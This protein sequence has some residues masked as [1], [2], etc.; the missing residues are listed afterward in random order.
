[1]DFLND[2]IQGNDAA[3]SNKEIGTALKRNA[4]YVFRYARDTSPVSSEWAVVSLLT[5]PTE[6]S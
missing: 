2:E 3:D 1:M 5:M 6:K 4:S